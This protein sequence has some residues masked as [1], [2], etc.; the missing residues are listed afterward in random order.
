MQ[1]LFTF[2]ILCLGWLITSADSLAVKSRDLVTR[3]TEVVDDGV[4]TRILYSP[5][6]WTHAKNQDAS[7]VYGGTES[8]SHA[9]DA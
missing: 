3:A 6:G 2:A 5:S 4:T 9:P 1:L 8:Y 7:K